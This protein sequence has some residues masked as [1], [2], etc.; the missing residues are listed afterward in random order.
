MSVCERV[1]RLVAYELDRSVEDVV[2]EASLRDWLEADSLEMVEI[3]AS[4][5]EEFGIEIPDRDVVSLSTIADVVSYID[6]RL[7]G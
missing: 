6:E 2:P 7:K 5:E 1:Q 3:T 4:L